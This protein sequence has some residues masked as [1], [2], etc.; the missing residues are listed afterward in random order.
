VA[1]ETL[2]TVDENEQPTVAI[3]AT[4]QQ[5]GSLSYA[6]SGP[7]SGLFTINSSGVIA[8]TQPFDFEAPVDAD[9]D[10][11]YR[12]IYEVT[13]SG[14]NL[15]EGGLLLLTVRNVDGDAI[16]KLEGSVPGDQWGLS[17]TAVPN[18]GDLDSSV[19]GED[20]VGIGLRSYSNSGVKGALVRVP[21]L[22]SD[23]EATI[24]IDNVDRTAGLTFIETFATDASLALR[25]DPSFIYLQN[26]TNNASDILALNY[27]NS[28]PGKGANEDRMIAG[29][30]S[31][32]FGVQSFNRELNRARVAGR[33]IS[34]RDAADYNAQRV[35]FG[36][37]FDNDGRDEYIVKAA[38]SLIV[39]PGAIVFPNSGTDFLDSNDGP[40]NVRAIQT[41]NDIVGIGP[42]I[43]GNGGADIVTF[44]Q[45]GGVVLISGRAIT[46]ASGSAITLADGEFRS[47][48]INDLGTIQVRKIAL[49]DL[50]D[51]DAPEIVF[52]A[53]ASSDSDAERSVYILKGSTYRRSTQS[54]NGDLAD[55]DALIL[56]PASNAAG[57]MVDFEILPD[58]DGDGRSDLFIGTD[59]DAYVIE[60]GSLAAPTG[61]QDIESLPVGSYFRV[62][63]DGGGYDRPLVSAAAV[64]DETSGD[65]GLFIGS[66]SD[67]SP[68]EALD[69]PDAEGS[70][71]YLPSQRVRAA[72]GYTDPIDLDAFSG[73]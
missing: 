32:D 39:Y 24:D 60:G 66:P 52:V 37:D 53:A 11:V 38:N 68:A 18:F 41:D 44:Q 29:F 61:T 50:T 57:R 31:D 26:D 22:R 72:F 14:S 9:Q 16:V 8:A 59:G 2:R 69:D 17:L 30:V 10:N 36:A 71:Y 15:T 46:K 43:F 54:F 45:G 55:F 12:V 62:N 4:A 65:R 49:A 25:T 5:G 27:A 21:T 7:D 40:P 58:V 42:D 70:V 19:S 33:Y 64:S 3:S 73:N 48:G 47:F 23:S 67:V 35:S 56:S 20:F 1:A 6:L 28:D 51:A 63:R 34:T 13:E